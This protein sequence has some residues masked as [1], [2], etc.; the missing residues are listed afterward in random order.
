MVT[1]ARVRLAEGN[2]WRKH[3]SYPN[4]WRLGPCPRPW[5][6]VGLGRTQRLYCWPHLPKKYHQ[7]AEAALL[8]WR[9]WDRAG[10]RLAWWSRLTEWANASLADA[11]EETFRQIRRRWAA[12]VT[13]TATWDVAIPFPQGPLLEIAL[14]Q[15]GYRPFEGWEGYQ[16]QTPFWLAWL[17]VRGHQD[18]VKAVAVEVDRC[19]QYALET[20]VEQKRRED[21]ERWGAPGVVFI[22]P[23]DLRQ[24]TK[25]V[26]ARVAEKIARLRVFEGV[27][28]DGL[29]PPEEGGER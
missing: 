13:P 4:L 1:E 26:A 9:W 21:A 17:Y 23:S 2:E 28:G 18:G 7:E 16:R 27:A 11:D 10:R 5:F 12:R 25:D 20:F 19:L 8:L 22:T 15:R 6:A 24:L 29:E 3:C 14:R